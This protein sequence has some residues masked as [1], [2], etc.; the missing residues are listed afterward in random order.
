VADGAVR[1]G[2]L[3]GGD[4]ARVRRSVDRLSRLM[5]CHRPGV[6][7]TVDFDPELIR[8]DIDPVELAERLIL[9]D[10]RRVSICLQ[11]PPGTGKSAWV[12]HLADRL[13]MEVLIRRASDLMSPYV[14]ET[15]QRIALAFGMARDAGAFLVFDEADSLLGERRDARHSWEVSRVN[16]MLTWMESHPLPFACTTNLG[17]SLDGA[18]A[19]RFLFK[20]TLDFL[21]RDRSRLAFRRWFGREAPPALD[22]VEELTPGDFEVVRRKARVMGREEDA[23]ELVA[24]LGAE[25][26]AR[27]GR[28]APVG[29]LGHGGACR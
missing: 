6:R 7:G 27:P 17:G 14:G 22:G 13:G 12:R 10:E 21:D 11:G 19:R 25:V 5:G 20:V 29:F 15:E 3:G 16:E 8:A 26:A 2:R 18:S 4:I 24:L 1:A 28:R 9:G 23:E